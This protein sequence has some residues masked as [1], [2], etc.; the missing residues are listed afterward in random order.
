M[1]KEQVLEALKKSDV[2][3]KAAQVVELTGL[4]RADVDKAC[5]ALKKE[6]LVES[7]KACFYQAVK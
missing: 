2:P 7:P 5:K 6:G 1:A 3:L 4:A